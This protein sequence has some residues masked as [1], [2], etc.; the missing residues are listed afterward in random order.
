MTTLGKVL[1]FVNLALSV[2][3][4][5]WAQGIYASRIDWSAQTGKDGRPNGELK[6]RQ[7]RITELNTA[8]GPAA[9]SWNEGRATVARLDTLRDTERQWYEGELALLRSGATKEHPARVIKLNKGEAEPTKP[10]INDRPVTEPGKD[11]YGK[12]LQSLV[13]YRTAEEVLNQ[14]IDTQNKS[15]VQAIEEDSRLTNLIA[16]DP[17]TGAKGLQQRILDERAK[18]QQAVN[19]EQFVRPLLINAVVNSDLVFRRQRSLEARIKE[20]EKIGVAVK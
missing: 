12:P 16:G 19:E 20:L 6:A 15:L 13:A 5:G 2:V 8:I 17:G 10:G 9:F 4:A 11:Q 7:E 18:Y 14:Q 1:V 3:M